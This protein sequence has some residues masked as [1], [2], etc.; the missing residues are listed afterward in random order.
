MTFNSNCGFCGR[1]HFDTQESLEHHVD[2]CAPTR[3]FRARFG[4]GSNQVGRRFMCDPVSGIASLRPQH[5]HLCPWCM[6]TFAS[7]EEASQHRQSCTSR[8]GAQATY[9]SPPQPISRVSRPNDTTKSTTKGGNL[10]Q[11]LPPQGPQCIDSNA[12]LTTYNTPFQSQSLRRLPQNNVVSAIL[13]EHRTE[14][15][16]FDPHADEKALMYRINEPPS[17]VIT[18]LLIDIARNNAEA[19][20]IPDAPVYARLLPTFKY[21]TV[22]QPQPEPGLASS[23]LS[24]FTARP[25][26]NEL[27]AKKT[28]KPSGIRFTMCEGCDRYCK[29]ISKEADVIYD[30]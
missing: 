11:L 8:R 6:A 5:V 4:T 24:Q 3:G 14:S 18:S 23:K 20:S 12:I 16:Y 19:R 9:Q 2:S 26:S 17:H 7:P 21:A 10:R 15:S 29:H 30:I 1:P 28:R 13:A 27:S 25:R 22:P